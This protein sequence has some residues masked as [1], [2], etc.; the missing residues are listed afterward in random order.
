[1]PRNALGTCIGIIAL[2]L[3]STGCGEL[4]IRTW[5]TVIES[6]SSGSVEVGLGSPP[7]VFP[8]ERVQGGFLTTVRIDTREIADGPLHGTIEIEDL[9]IA[10]ENVGGL[11]KVCTWGDPTGAS[12]GTVVLDI[13][14]EGPSVADVLLDLRAIS[15]L[16]VNLGLPVADLEQATTLPLGNG[17]TV[18]SLLASTQ[19]GSADGLFAAQTAFSGASS[20]GGIAAT[21]NLDLSVTNGAEPPSFDA[22]HLGF[23]QPYFDEQGSDLFFGLNSKSTYL[24]VDDDDTAA[25]P[26]AIDLADV[27]AAPGDTLRLSVV[28]TYADKTLLRDGDETRLTAVFSASD[29]LGA[30]G[31]RH[32]VVDAID[33][34]ADIRTSGYV[35]CF[36]FFCSFDGTDIREDFRVDPSVDVV[37]PAGAGYLFVSPTPRSQEWGDNSAFGL[38]VTVEVGP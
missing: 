26:L 28:G 7:P 16:Q 9:R 33:A 1:M 35:D 18:D 2:A 15:G 34:G 27:G 24:R 5:V 30:P 4:S 23:C 25:Q 36:L 19:T 17:L 13:L 12:G 14:G 31:D 38:G 3:V 21:F 11:G 10:A 6:E 29:I 37:V 20:L 32:R 8:L 22:D